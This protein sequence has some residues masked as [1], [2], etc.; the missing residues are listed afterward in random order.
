M[1]TKVS[2]EE[3]STIL[4][5]DF[6]EKANV[7]PP[8]KFNPQLTSRRNETYH[9]RRE[10]I[11]EQVKGFVDF[12]HVGSIA[13]SAI[14]EPH[15]TEIARF[16]YDASQAQNEDERC[17]HKDGRVD[18]SSLFPPG[19]AATATAEFEEIHRVATRALDPLDSSGVAHTHTSEFHQT[20]H[21][22]NP[23]YMH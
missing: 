23:C 2:D 16:G 21:H 5:A 18:L 3:T 4:R 1:L 20:V 13:V 6:R 8:R 11:K 22:L 9:S 7:W 17:S 15:A 19:G 10:K 12:A 14:E